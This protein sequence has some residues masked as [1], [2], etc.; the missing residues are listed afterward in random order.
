MVKIV[1]DFVISLDWF[2]CIL[3]ESPFEAGL[4]EYT[5]G[6]FVVKKWFNPQTGASGNRQYNDIYEVYYQDR[7]FGNFTANPK[8]SIIAEDSI[9]FKAD[10]E[11][12]YTTHFFHVFSLFLSAFDLKFKSFSRIDLAIDFCQGEDLNAFFHRF[13]EYYTLKGNKPENKIYREGSV[14]TGFHLGKSTAQKQLVCYNKTK[15]ILERS[16]KNYIIDFWEQN[17]LVPR[18]YEPSIH[19]DVYRLELRLFRD[20]LVKFREVIFNKEERKKGFPLSFDFFSSSN[21]MLSLYRDSCSNFFEFYRTADYYKGCNISR[22]ESFIPIDFTP[23]PFDQV[24]LVRKYHRSA[25]NHITRYRRLI[26]SFLRQYIETNDSDYLVKM[27]TTGIDYKLLGFI[28]DKLPRWIDEITKESEKD[29]GVQDINNI[30]LDLQ[31]VHGWVTM[32]RKNRGDFVSVAMDS[33]RLSRSLQ[34]NHFTPNLVKY[35]EDYFEENWHQ[36][37]I[38][39]H[40]ISPPF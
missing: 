24:R 7:I 13:D 31:K 8:T 38:K 9:T 27:Y 36:D 11:L 10:N 37:S 35:A 17:G 30:N 6:D 2:Q 4:L 29:F 16:Q 34:N 39:S 20:V 5:S 40:T 26:K 32:M 25:K 28:N 3:I 15:E 14:I 23:F 33:L 12:L 19:G 22:L 1:K 21:K 18:G